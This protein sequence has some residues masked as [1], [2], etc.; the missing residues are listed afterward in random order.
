VLSVKFVLVIGDGMADRPVEKFGGK[1]PLEA[2][3]HPHMDEIA[4]K[5]TCG[6]LQT[7]PPKAATG[8]EAATLSLLGYNP[9]KYSLGRG[10]LEALAVGAPLGWDDVAFRCNLV[11][12]RDGILV[13]YSAGHITTEEA[14]ELIQGLN[15]KLGRGEVAFYPGLSYRH[16]LVLRG[17]K[18]SPAV[19]CFPP[20]SFVGHPVSTLPVT[21]L[22][23]EAEETARLLNRLAAE[24]KA[25]LTSHPVNMRRAAEGKSMGNMAWFWGPGRRPRVPLF[26]ELHGLRGAVISAVDIVKGIGLCAGMELITVPGAT[27]YFDTDYEGKADYALRALEK[28]DMV[29]VHVEAPDEAG[30]LGDFHLKVKAIEDLDRRLLGRLLSGL[31]GDYTVGVVADHATPVEVRTHTRDPVPFA[32]YRKA[33]ASSKPAKRFDEASVKSLGLLLESGEAFIRLFLGLP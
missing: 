9:E 7:I 29:I 8:S 1:T 23:E 18:Y 6:L 16:V 2:A 13:D 32:V 14:R 30:H 26:H 15:Q 17:R 33:E 5:G 22:A 24:S 3:H 19:R 25:L 31:E 10:P 11:T 12:E 28:Y 20:H 21:P 4:S 27:G